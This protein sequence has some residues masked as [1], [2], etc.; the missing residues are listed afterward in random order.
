MADRRARFE[1]KFRNVWS[2]G[3]TG[4]SYLQ[5][6]TTQDPSGLISRLFKETMIADEW[7]NQQ[8]KRTYTSKGKEVTVEAHHLI[9]VTSDDRV[10]EVIEEVASWT[11]AKKGDVPFDLVVTPLATGSKEYIEWV[12]VQ[13]LKKDDD[14]AFF[15]QQSSEALRPIVDT[16]EDKNQLQTKTEASHQTSSG[17]STDDEEDDEEED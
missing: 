5:M 12:K 10:P 4:V 3:S 9:F 6:T 1:K 13:S 15:N 14:A 16:I 11:N 8:V 7:N 17:Q 2:T